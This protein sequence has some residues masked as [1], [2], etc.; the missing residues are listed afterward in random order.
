MMRPC[1]GSASSGYTMAVP[2]MKYTEGSFPRR[3]DTML[4]AYSLGRNWWAW[5]T[6]RDT[7]THTSCERSRTHL[8]VDFL[9]L[10]VLFFVTVL[11]EHTNITKT[12]PAGQTWNVSGQVHSSSARLCE[13][14][15]YTLMGRN[16]L[17]L[18]TLWTCSTML[19]TGDATG[20]KNKVSVHNFPL[21]RGKLCAYTTLTSMT[22]KVEPATLYANSDWHLE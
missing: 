14:F 7:N 12:N 17:S 19:A 4:R 3:H 8:S 1:L 18:G 11:Q 21:C 22:V 20:K 16:R 5:R 2:T 10:S 6:N 15:L 13:T 9:L